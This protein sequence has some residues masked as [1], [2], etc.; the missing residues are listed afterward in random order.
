VGAGAVSNHDNSFWSKA[1]FYFY[2]FLFGA[3][4][5]AVIGQKVHD[6]LMPALPFLIIIAVLIIIVRLVFMNSR[7]KW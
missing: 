5:L 4:F 2:S 1:K 6:L 3:F 7:R